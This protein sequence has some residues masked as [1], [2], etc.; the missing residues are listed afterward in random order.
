MSLFVDTSAFCAV[1]DRRD[2]HHDAADKTWAELME[3]REALHTS[4]YVLIETMA[5]LQSRI[6][7]EGMGAFVA[8]VMP[9][10]T[11]HWVTEGVHRSAQHALLVAG[12]RQL[13]LVDCVNFELMR[14]MGLRDV[15]CFDEHFREQGF[16]CVAG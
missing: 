10:I 2:I 12:R 14:R 11:V 6:G 5:L 15:F 3:S 8:D 4:N 13:S 9:V 7:M 1:L 16:H